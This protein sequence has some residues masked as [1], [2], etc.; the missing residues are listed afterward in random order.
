ML[1]RRKLELKQMLGQWY[2]HEQSRLWLT[3]F[4]PCLPGNAD[5][6]ARDRSP[7]LTSL[8]LN[9]DRSVQPHDQP[10]DR[11][12]AFIIY[13]LSKKIQ[14]QSKLHF[15]NNFILYILF[16]PRDCLQIVILR[17]TIKKYYYYY[18]YIRRSNQFW[19]IFAKKKTFILERC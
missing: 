5:G 7:N 19:G 6:N 10:V 1:I 17:E 16:V 9:C 11:F 13:Q 2:S 12:R 3:D 18:Y 4:W 15:I 14:I 8:N